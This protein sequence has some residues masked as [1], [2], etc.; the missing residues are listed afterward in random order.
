MCSPNRMS[1][2]PCSSPSGPAKAVSVCPHRGVRGSPLNGKTR[3]LGAGSG[4]RFS[5]SMARAVT[6]RQTAASMRRVVS[7][8]GNPTVWGVRRGLARCNIKLRIGRMLR[9]T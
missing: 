2:A 6:G 9:D 3:G 8:Q 4:E 7:T 5:S 1:L